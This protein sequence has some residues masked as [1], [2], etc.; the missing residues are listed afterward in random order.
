ML[1]ILPGESGRALHVVIS[2][3]ECDT[4][5]CVVGFGVY[6]AD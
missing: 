4:E 1:L 5:T 2:L 6:E 3:N